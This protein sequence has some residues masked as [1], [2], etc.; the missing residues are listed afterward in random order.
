MYRITQLRRACPVRS[1][2][3]EEF[4]E[5]SKVAETESDSMIGK[6]RIS[7][8]VKRKLAAI[9]NTTNMEET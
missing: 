3:S 8:M 7:Y 4:V 5:E 2:V 6:A 1:S 9:Q